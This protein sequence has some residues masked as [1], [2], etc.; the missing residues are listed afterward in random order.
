MELVANELLTIIEDLLD[1]ILRKSIHNAQVGITSVMY[2]IDEQVVV[3]LL[4]KDVDGDTLDAHIAKFFDIDA[5]ADWLSKN[6]L[7]SRLFM[8]S[9][10]TFLKR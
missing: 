6:L 9:M 5:A 2:D 3:E 8:A 1:D 10:A 7:T 4:H